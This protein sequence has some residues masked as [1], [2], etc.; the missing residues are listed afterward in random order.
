MD[1]LVINGG[2]KLSGKIKIDSAKNSVLP[3]LA[4]T[5]LTEE[6]VV[7]LDCPRISDVFAMVNILEKVGAKTAWQDNNL[8]VKA[9][10][11]T[12]YSVPESLAKE[13]RTSVLFLGALSSRLK[14][15]EIAYPGGCDLGGR[16]IDIHIR[17]IEYL[18]GTITERNQTIYCSCGELKGR[19]LTLPFPSVGATENVLL[20]SVMAEGETVIKNPAREPEIQDL[21]NM[22]NLM[23]AKIYGAGS[24]EIRVVGVKSLHGVTYKPI[25]DRIEAGTYLIAVATAGGEIE[26]SNVY[27][28]NILSLIG[29][30]CE[31]TCKINIKNDIIYLK[32]GR[33]RK[34]FN[35]STGPYPMF[36][37]DLQAQATVL[38]SVSHGT[39]VIRENVFENRF[40]HAIELKK[41]GA[42]ISV[43][44]N[45]AIVHG[46]DRLHG[47]TV[48]SHDL[49]CSAALVTAGLVAEG[50]TVVKD[51]RF[52]DRGYSDMENKLRSIGGDVVRKR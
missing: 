41:M 22:L 21:S 33:T 26:I 2:L 24:E 52:L 9:D 46:M 30:L 20:A 6:E 48:D 47:A 43:L 40:C 44:G 36:P 4:A 10:N 39:S 23:G 5:L 28:E 51:L 16:P 34:S 17:A 1:K 3:I 12:S 14:K 7:I 18:G 29:K 27:A 25:P 32:S 15:A 42:D 11:L 50:K 19:T 35:I 45:T 37:T 49:R 31:N 38:S 8:I 13:L